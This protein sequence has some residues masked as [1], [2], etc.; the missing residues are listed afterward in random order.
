MKAL[1]SFYSLVK[2]RSLIISSSYVQQVLKKGDFIFI[3]LLYSKAS[4]LLSER[5]VRKTEF[6]S[7]ETR[8]KLEGKKN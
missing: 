7:I 4:S 2:T 1:F 8:L 5:A 6:P 3:G